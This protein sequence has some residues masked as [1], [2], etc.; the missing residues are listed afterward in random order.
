MEHRR[1]DTRLGSA[2]LGSLECLVQQ[3]LDERY[4]QNILSALSFAITYLFLLKIFSQVK[5]NCNN[6]YK[7]LCDIG[8]SWIHA[9]E[10]KADL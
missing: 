2:L 3:A 4:G 7:T 6:D 1:D 9:E 5:C 10:L 8:V